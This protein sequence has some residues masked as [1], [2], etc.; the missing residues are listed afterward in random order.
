MQFTK[1]ATILLVSLMG[2]ATIAALATDDAAVDAAPAVE[3]RGFGCP[4]NENEC[5]AHCLSIGRKFGFC[6]GPLRA[7]CTCGK[8]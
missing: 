7:T 1:F 4:F 5:H 6:A 8:Q 3:K 2:N